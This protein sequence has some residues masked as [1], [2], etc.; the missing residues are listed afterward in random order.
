MIFMYQN[1]EQVIDL[2]GSGYAP[3]CTHVV[4]LFYVLQY[5]AFEI[6]HGKKPARIIGG[7]TPDRCHTYS[8]QGNEEKIHQ[9][10]TT[11][12][13]LSPNTLYVHATNRYYTPQGIYV[14][15]LGIETLRCNVNSTL[16]G[17]A[18]CIEISIPKAFRE[19]S[20]SIQGWESAHLLISLKSNER[21]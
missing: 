14:L 15:Q 10:C 17:Q 6:G 5:D 7:K 18:T 12:N 9:N 19:T 8:Y 21:L 2:T 16:H 13:A 20:N 3:N 4:S 11:P 1:P